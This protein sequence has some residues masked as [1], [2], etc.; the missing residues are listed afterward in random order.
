MSDSEERVTAT[1][2]TMPSLNPSTSSTDTVTLA[3][4]KVR[5]ISRLAKVDDLWVFSQNIYLFFVW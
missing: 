3:I 4:S 2:E 1:I 5:S